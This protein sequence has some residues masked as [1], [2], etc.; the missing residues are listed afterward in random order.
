MASVIKSLDAALKMQAV[1]SAMF[2]DVA[3]TGYT[4]SGRGAIVTVFPN[5]DALES[6]EKAVS[7]FM[8][9]SELVKFEYADV[10][11][12]VD[13]Y[14]PQQ[15]YVT[16][17]VVTVRQKENEDDNSILLC[18]LV[19]KDLH[20]TTPPNY[21]QHGVQ[22]RSSRVQ[23]SEVERAHLL[24]LLKCALQVCNGTSNLKVC[25]GC[26]DARYCSKA[27]QLA[28]RTAHRNICQELK[29]LKLAAKD[30]LRQH[31]SS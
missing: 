22:L 10:M 4:Q 5:I 11:S 8:P 29:I 21:D 15:W 25:S 6:G 24:C 27:C 18:K 31:A 9:R 19:H 12:F 28:D 26:N 1:D 23:E 2:F 16:L 7:F 17:A 14:D 13:M 3:H 20:T 30:F